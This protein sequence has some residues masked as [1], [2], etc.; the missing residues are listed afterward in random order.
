MTRSF[1]H[2]LAGNESQ[3]ECALSELLMTHAEPK[4]NNVLYSSRLRD[5]F[6]R[7]SVGEIEDAKQDLYLQITVS[8]N[9]LKAK[10]H[11]QP[12]N[13]FRNYVVVSAVNFCKELLR[14]KYWQRRKLRNRVHYILSTRDE[15]CLWNDNDDRLLCGLAGWRGQ[16]A[17]VGN[18]RHSELLV[19]LRRD[20]RVNELSRN[21]GRVSDLRQLLS[22]VFGHARGPITFKEVVDIVADLHG[23]NE[24]R[25]ILNPTPQDIL[26]RVS[27]HQSDFVLS[28]EM[29]E[30][31]RRLWPEITRLPHDQR[32]HF[33]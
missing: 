28:L 31:I 15:F 3:S 21:G 22:L 30:I 10:V 26:N 11:P 33:F 13:N 14:K 9:N 25:S 27:H 20:T 7:S 23:A 32:R 1:G 6:V 18:G 12:I 29:M 8:L 16:E 24:H 19:A 17:P 5:V 2:T 4:I